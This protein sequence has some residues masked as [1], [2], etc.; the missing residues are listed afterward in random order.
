MRLTVAGALLSILLLVSGYQEKF[1]PYVLLAG[2]LILLP[3]GVSVLPMGIIWVLISGLFFLTF[4]I[5]SSNP[6]SF[7]FFAL[8]LAFMPSADKLVS[9]WNYLGSY[10]L[11]C[12]LFLLFKSKGFISLPALAGL[13]GLL[14][15]L[16]F[17]FLS[18][19]FLDAILRAL[20]VSLSFLLTII[21]KF[22]RPFWFFLAIWFAGSL[23]FRF[24]SRRY[25]RLT[26]WLSIFFLTLCFIFL[27][28]MPSLEVLRNFLSN[29]FFYQFSFLTI[30]FFGLTTL[31]PMHLMKILNALWKQIFT[32]KILC[33]S[34]TFL[35]IFPIFLINLYAKSIIT[36][37]NVSIISFIIFFASVY[38]ALLTIFSPS[39]L[40]EHFLVSSLT[41]SIFA[42]FLAYSGLQKE[43]WKFLSQSF[44]ISI[45]LAGPLLLVIWLRGEEHY[46]RL[47]W[48]EILW[49]AGFGILCLL[50]FPHK[51][52]MPWFAVIFA[53]Y[54]CFLRFAFSK[55][56]FAEGKIFL[57][58]IAFIFGTYLIASFKVCPP[59]LCGIWSLL[60]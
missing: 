21:P 40:R 41:F 28:P 3:Y 57:K 7:V 6:I 16:D 56:N 10:G 14:I 15:I 20:L 19:R 49:G 58:S 59:I 11:P 26:P 31:L 12:F 25:Q 51:N 39:N 2:S 33:R 34:L 50:F 1:F 5:L 13:W 42:F 38:P 52:L 23:F 36:D 45:Y 37:Y 35:V 8:Y 18:R 32:S 17:F 4:D 29:G 27:R 55:I 48:Q 44:L 53:F 24:W 9:F 30:L 47:Y 54:A 46:L 60:N 43:V 22:P